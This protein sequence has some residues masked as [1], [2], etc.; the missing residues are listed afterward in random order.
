RHYSTLG[1]D[2]SA[3]ALWIAHARAEAV[4]RLW[5]DPGPVAGKVLWRQ[6]L[7]GA[8]P[9]EPG[10]KDFEKRRREFVARTLVPQRTAGAVRDESARVLCVLCALGREA[11]GI[12]PLRL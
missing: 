1:Q 7:V 6:D 10:K 5:R 12:D 11:F 8:A 2:T 4:L 3:A 9:Q